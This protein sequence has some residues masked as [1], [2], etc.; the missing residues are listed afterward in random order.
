M[1]SQ[2]GSRIDVP[3]TSGKKVE[4]I[5]I[6]GG[7]AIPSIDVNYYTYGEKFN[8]FGVQEWKSTQNSIVVSANN[9]IAFATDIY[10]E[11]MYEGASELVFMQKPASNFFTVPGISPTGIIDVN[12]YGLSAAL[13]I[14]SAK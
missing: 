3:V 6:Y 11:I 4:S 13:P 2:V 9:S 1:I 5:T 8:F 14:V 10:T 12:V 7:D